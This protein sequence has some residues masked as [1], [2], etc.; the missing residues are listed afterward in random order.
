MSNFSRRLD[1]LRQWIGLL[2]LLL[3]PHHANSAGLYALMS[4]KSVFSDKTLFI[5]MGYWEN[6]RE[7][8]EACYAL[9]RVLAD[10]AN[11]SESDTVLDAGF[12]F[13]EQDLFWAK[14]FCPAS[15]IGLNITKLQVEIATRRVRE[16][17]SAERIKLIAGSATD[18]P[19][20]DRSVTKVVALESAFHFRTRQRFFEEAFRVLK[21][22]GRIALADLLFLPRRNA[23]SAKDWLFDHLGRAAWQIPKSNI[24]SIDSYE[25]KLREA[26]FRDIQICSIREQVLVPFRS[27]VR[28]R[29]K[30]PY[31]ADS[32]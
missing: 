1:D 17:D 19:I 4:T 15:I 24:D 29:L 26:G 20:A 16:S 12:G 13:A 23:P 11:M 5:N 7:Y 28:S 8:D 22:G 27:Y 32:F 3:N 6:T 9:A 10:A 14:T 2:F 25:A 18:M 31:L 21:P 30:S